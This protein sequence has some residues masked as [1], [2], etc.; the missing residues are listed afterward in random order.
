MAE[1]IDCWYCGEINEIA[2][3]ANPYN[4]KV[5]VHCQLCNS[6][7]WDSQTGRLEKDVLSMA[8][9]QNPRIANHQGL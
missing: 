6:T 9:L 4:D 3:I 5:V 8:S 7:I 2:Q 1:K